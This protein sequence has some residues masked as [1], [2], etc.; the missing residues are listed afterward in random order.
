MISV[1]FTL[2]LVLMTKPVMLGIFF[3]IAAM[4]VLIFV[5]F[6]TKILVLGVYSSKSSI[7]F[8]NLADQH[9]NTIYQ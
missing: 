5:F 1:I 6:L 2:K 9:H 4:L 8:Q 7:L 3:S